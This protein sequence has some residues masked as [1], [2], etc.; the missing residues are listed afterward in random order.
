M[1]SRT[2]EDAVLWETRPSCLNFF[3]HFFFFFLIIP[4]MVALWKRAGL[5]M[6]VYSDRVV[7][8]KGVLS[9]DIKEIFCTDVRTINVK[10][11]LFQ[12]IFGIGDLYI[13]TAG[14]ADYEDAARGLPD[15]KGAK[16]LIIRLKRQGAGAED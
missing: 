10:Q 6:T 16:D 2:D 8:E 3:W 9:K 4:P 11:T 1:T 7:V 13:A 12:R 14:T 5:K 15:P